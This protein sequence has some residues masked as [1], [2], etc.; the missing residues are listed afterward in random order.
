[1]NPTPIKIMSLTLSL[2][3]K[4]KCS[5]SYVALIPLIFFVFFF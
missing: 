1:M 5:I 4:I 2:L 3:A